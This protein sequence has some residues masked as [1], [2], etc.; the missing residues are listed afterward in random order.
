M[1]RECL[2]LKPLKEAAASGSTITNKIRE[3]L[4]K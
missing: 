2:G 1:V 4:E 3:N